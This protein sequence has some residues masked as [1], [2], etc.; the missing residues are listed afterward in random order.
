VSGDNSNP[1]GEL[2]DLADKQFQVFPGGHGYNPESVRMCRYDFKGTD[3][4][5][6]G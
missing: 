1:G 4:N 6:T 5:R 2:P 3:A